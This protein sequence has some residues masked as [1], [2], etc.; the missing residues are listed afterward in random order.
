MNS[1]GIVQTTLGI[2]IVIGVIF[3][4]ITPMN[5][6]LDTTTNKTCYDTYCSKTTLDEFDK[7]IDLGIEST[8][9]LSSEHY[10]L[11]DGYKV[12][13]KCLERSERVTDK[14][15]ISFGMRCEI[16]NALVSGDEQ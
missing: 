12:T 4:M 3:F 7:C 8:G 10:W 15:Y 16:D 9:F 1:L 5:K 2:I 14:E 13:S 11:C 6:V